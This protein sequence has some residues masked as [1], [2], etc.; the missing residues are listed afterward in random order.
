[1]DTGI[2]K[3]KRDQDYTNWSSFSVVG[4]D[5]PNMV[6]HYKLLYKSIKKCTPLN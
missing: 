6:E 1:M 4:A 3:L 5:V 2:W